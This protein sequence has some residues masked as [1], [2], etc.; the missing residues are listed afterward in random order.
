MF[1]VKTIKLSKKY[2]NQNHI[3]LLFDASATVPCLYPLLYSTTVLR[4]QSFATQQSDMLALKFWYQKYST[5]FCESFLSS[6]YEPEIFLNE[7]DNFI[8]F[9]E[10]NKKLDST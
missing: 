9:L 6:K 1:V 4:F 2:S 5:L 10:N 8:V 3:V 7:I